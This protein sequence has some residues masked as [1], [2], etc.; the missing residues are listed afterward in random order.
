MKAIND[1]AEFDSEELDDGA[2]DYLAGFSG[3]A[4]MKL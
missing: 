1:G 2:I 4:N 3:A